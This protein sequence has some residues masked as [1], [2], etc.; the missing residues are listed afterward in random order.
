[1]PDML[2]PKLTASWEKGLEMVAKKEIQPEEFMQ[3]LEKY[4]KTKF[5]KFVYR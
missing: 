1:M 3:K 4:I 2:N 5:D